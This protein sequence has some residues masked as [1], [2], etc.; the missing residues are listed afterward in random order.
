[1]V[2]IIEII[3]EAGLEK[4]RQFKVCELELFVGLGGDIGL[5]LEFRSLWDIFEIQNRWCRNH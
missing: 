5:H 3:E 4:G 2:S 1:M